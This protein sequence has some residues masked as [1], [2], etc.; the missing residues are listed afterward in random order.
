MNS[1]FDEFAIHR[2]LMKIGIQGNQTEMIWN[3]NQRDILFS[4][5]VIFRTENC[6][7]N[8]E[9]FELICKIRDDIFIVGF[10]RRLI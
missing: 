8:E 3:Y 2:K 7:K 5:S 4:K 10:I 1:E 6:K 9:Y